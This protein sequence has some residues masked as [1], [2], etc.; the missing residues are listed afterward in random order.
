MK[1]FIMHVMNE[2]VCCQSSDGIS[3]PQTNFIIFTEYRIARSHYLQ[4]QLCL[5]TG[6]SS[7]HMKTTH[8]HTPNYSY[9][10]SN[11]IN[12]ISHASVLFESE[13]NR[14]VL[15]AKID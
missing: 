13:S 8:T 9:F 5:F 10:A 12:S 14:G 6:K 7:Q 4:Q 15:S 3:R 2:I 11:W 1:L